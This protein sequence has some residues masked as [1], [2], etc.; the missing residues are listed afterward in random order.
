VD[1]SLA[2]FL[3]VYAVMLLG[4]APALALDRT[5][6]C[7][8]GAVVLVLGGALTS[9]AAWHAIDV[10]TIGLLFGMML[11]SAQFA[12]S[13]FYAR[14]TSRL[15]AR[16]TSPAR[17]LGELVGV[18]GALSA[19]LTNDVVCVAVAPVL[20]DV[21]ARRGLDPVPFLLALA[22]SANVGSAATLI[23]NPQNML[24]G[25]Q[26]ALPFG[27]YLL[28]G[29]LPAALGLAVVWAVLAR[30][31]RGRWQRQSTFAATAPPPPPVFDGWQTAKALVVLAALVVG[32]LTSGVPRE[33]QAMLAGAMLLVSRT[34]PTR[35]LLAQVDWPLLVLFAGLF[36]VNN[37]FERAGHAAN[38]F[39]W[40]QAHGVDVAQ[41]ATLFAAG[42]V[43]SN[44]VS[45]VPLT[46]L[47]LPAAKHELAGPILALATTLAGN[48]LLV[49]SIA[50]LI[51]VEA[52]TRLGV[53]P[54]ARGWAAEHARTG[55]PITL[56]TLAIAAGWL[57][58]RHG[59]LAR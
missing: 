27:G 32:L 28:D 31:Y 24:I 22:A 17:L 35:T 36:V 6:A 2:V 20:V 37:A 40:L 18:A 7:L 42:V 26:L 45:N 48:L 25:Q 46:M 51:V 12:R 52:A 30:A 58:L 59:V 19:L 56:G 14:L 4:R 8:L 33:V 55:V 10:G 9:T 50:N 41:P 43:G 23:G 57:W 47:L 11:V 16:P 5:G 29:A 53:A 39:A 38:G 1:L 13:G 44:L 3:A 54:R 49:G 34:T 21:C 15:A